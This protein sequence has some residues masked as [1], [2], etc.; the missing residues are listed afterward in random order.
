MSSRSAL[1]ASIAEV[2]AELVRL[3]ARLDELELQAEAAPDF[4]VV[5]SASAGNETGS[6]S[7][8]EGGRSGPSESE[9]ARAATLTGQF[10]LRALTGDPRGESGRSLVKLQNRY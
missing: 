3:A 4:E 9:R 1:V 8:A 10:F 7:S 2:R 6:R 5:R